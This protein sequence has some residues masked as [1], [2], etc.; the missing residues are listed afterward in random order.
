VQEDNG[1]ADSVPLTLEIPKDDPLFDMKVG[2]IS[3]PLQQLKD[4]TFNVV[5]NL[6]DESFEDLIGFARYIVA[7]EKDDVKF[8]MTTIESVKSGKGEK[9][10]LPK[11]SKENEAAAWR[12]IIRVVDRALRKFPTS[13]MEDEKILRKD[14]SERKLSKNVRHCIMYR[15]SEKVILHFLKD[16]AKRVEHL[17]TIKTYDLAKK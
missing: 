16:C 9:G 2:M 3:K 11:I 7:Q 12:F 17:L 10:I 8:H 1:H 6:T 5:A 13:L 14:K 4:K 15:K